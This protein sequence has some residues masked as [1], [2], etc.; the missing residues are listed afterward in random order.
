MWIMVLAA[1]PVVKASPVVDSPF[2][3]ITF[4]AFNEFIKQEFSSKISL[5]T[6]LVILFSLTE[7]PDLL[8]LHTRQ[9]YAENSS[10]H[11]TMASGWIKSLAWALKE[12]INQ[13]QAQPLKMKNMDKNRDENY[14]ITAFSLKLDALANLLGLH[15]YNHHGRFQSKLKPVSHTTIQPDMLFALLQQSVKLRPAIHDHYFN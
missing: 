7:N 4:K 5:S 8:N 15:L 14:T 12:N 13:N 1:F 2:L 11:Q 3:D 9:Q 6:V 10:E